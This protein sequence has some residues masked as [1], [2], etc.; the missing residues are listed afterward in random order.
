MM[1][2]SDVT[3]VRMNRIGAPGL[4]VHQ[5]LT[6]TVAAV[7]LTLVSTLSTL[8]HLSSALCTAVDVCGISQ[9]VSLLLYLFASHA[10]ACFLFCFY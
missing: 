7:T 5:T 1:S 2:Y 6:F 3:K 4:S 10:H 9:L 8:I